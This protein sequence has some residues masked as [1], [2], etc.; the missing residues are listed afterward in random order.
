MCNHGDLL[1]TKVFQLLGLW[2]LKIKM[3]QRKN[4]KHKKRIRLIF[5]V[6]KESKESVFLTSGGALVGIMNGVKHDKSVK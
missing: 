4:N 3:M 6:L 5:A 2:G 1:H